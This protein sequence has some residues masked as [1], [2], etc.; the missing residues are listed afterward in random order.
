MKHCIKSNTQ[1]KYWFLIF[2]WFQSDFQNVFFVL[3]LQNTYNFFRFRVQWGYIHGYVIYFVIFTKIEPL[4]PIK[5]NYLKLHVEKSRLNFGRLVATRVL[6]SAG[7]ARVMQHA[8][9]AAVRVC[10]KSIVWF[11]IPIWRTVTSTVGVLQWEYCNQFERRYKAVLQKRFD[12]TS[13]SSLLPVLVHRCLGQSIVVD[14][15]LQV[16]YYCWW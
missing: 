3:T 9:R 7:S 16:H 6:L 12:H 2:G 8:A 14:W 5:L 11:K 13:N 15:H 10:R 1:Y 4:K